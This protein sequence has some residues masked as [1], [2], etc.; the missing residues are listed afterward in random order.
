M[1]SQSRSKPARLADGILLLLFALAAFVALFYEPAFFLQCGWS[2]LHQGAAG[3]CAQ[4]WVGR[5]WLAY[6]RVEPAYADAPLFLQL[7][8]EFDSLLFGWFYLLSLAV[9]VLRRQDRPWYR[10]LATFVS[11]MMA[12]AMAYYL[13]WETLSYRQTGADIGAVYQYNGLWLLLFVLLM[14]R[15]H[16]LRPRTAPGPAARLLQAALTPPTHR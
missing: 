14:V 8:N 12:Y 4:S 16:L 10:G 7:A 1:D 11:G 13:S 3:S 15:L 2:G 5:A 6:L 9:F